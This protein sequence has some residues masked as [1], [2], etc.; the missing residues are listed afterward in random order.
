MRRS[1]QR[2][3]YDELLGVIRSVRRRWR[4]RMLLRGLAVVGAVAVA[5]LL[6]AGALLSA[7][8]PSQ[9]GVVAVR[10]AA[11][12]VIGL[13]ALLFLVRPLFRRVTD[14]DV[15]LYLEEHEPSLEAAVLSALEAGS[16]G[17]AG[18]AGAAGGEGSTRQRAAAAVGSDALLRRTLEQAIRRCHA[19][20]DG[21][22]VEQRS[23]ARAAGALALV[24]VVGALAGFLGPEGARLGAL[25]LFSAPQPV[26]AAGAPAIAVQ[27]GNATVARGA[28]VTI[29]ARVRNLDPS[30]VELVVQS[31]GDSVF[32]RLP[33]ARAADGSFGYLLFDLEQDAEYRVEAE[34]VRS[35]PFSLTVAELPYVD[36]L[37]LELRF[38][39][40]TGLPD[41][42]VEE[43][44][45]VTALRGTTARLTL[46]STVPVTAG[47]IVVD[48]GA[49]VPLTYDS[50]SGTLSGE[51]D[52]RSDGYYHIVL[53]AP[54][55]DVVEASPRYVIDALSDGEPIVAFEEPGRDERRTPIEEL[56][57]EARAEDDYGVADLTLHY[58]VNGGPERTEELYGGGGD[59]AEVTAG[60]TLY[61]EE[62]GLQP[63]DLI[64]YWATASDND[65]FAGGKAATS[66]IYF[67]QIRPFEREFRAAEQRQPPQGGQQGGQQDRPDGDLSQR[68]RQIV[69]G[70]FNLVRDS[71]SFDATDL[72]ES[73]NT[74]TL[75]QER[76]RD[77]AR[78]LA[79]RMQARRVTQDS[80][81]Q[82]IA[83]LLPQAAAEMDAAVEALR[84]GTVREALGPEQRALVLL[85]RAEAVFRE[86]QVSLGQQMGG[87]GQPG[88]APNA[89]D[90]ADL[91]ELEMDKLQ[92][93][94]E[95]V[96][97]GG[98]GGDSTTA[99]V[100]EAAERLE[101]L[102][103]RQQRE[104]E[105]RRREAMHGRGTA[106]GEA[107]RALAEQVEEE[108]RRLE[109]LSR[110]QRRPEL[111]EAARRLRDAAESMRRA[112]ASGQG[113]GSEQAEGAVD[114]LRDAR[115][116]LERTETDDLRRE[117]EEASQRADELAR[118]QAR[119]RREA[120]RL[121]ATAQGEERDERARELE[122]QK[123]RQQGDVES[124]EQDLRRLAGQAGAEEPDAAQQLRDAAGA[125]SNSQVEEKID[126]SRQLTRG[127]APEEY[128]RQLE[129]QIQQDLERVSQRLE[130]V[131]Q[132]IR[133]DRSEDG[134]ER[135]LEEA[136]DLARGL[137]SMRERGRELRE[138]ASGNPRGGRGGLNPDAIRQYRSEARQRLEDARELQQRLRQGGVA[139]GNL[140]EQMEGVLEGLDRLTDEG[141]YQDPEELAR[142]QSAL[143]DS[144]KR[145]ELQ[146]RIRL[147]GE[148]GVRLFQGGDGAV[149]AEYRELVEEYYRSLS[150]DGGQDGPGRQEDRQ[151]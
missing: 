110:D 96:N 142:L 47:G 53:E 9:Q 69:A 147:A 114:R 21:R 91:F 132:A 93:Q 1:E 59:L 94:Y 29:S 14:T 124:L 102:A 42:E 84:S 27:P 123:A 81:F 74:L 120:E 54:S 119:I 51:F 62:L 28:D 25:R 11:A 86:V 90:L 58:T 77:D 136:G 99:E 5:A 70:T 112:A 18:A 48:G 128:V 6:G 79:G 100:D 135:A 137:E 104:A 118:E 7:L 22:W 10:V 44:G 107:Q 125:I 39:A 117:A 75:S 3:A 45:D 109:R 33:M 72:R 130:G 2:M 140:E 127:G 37:G 88:G 115:R 52:V 20:D 65:G 106:G 98:G 43:G 89:E 26:E 151:P 148:Q 12:V 121:Q 68:Q 40:Y 17:P 138:S 34:G 144:A 50:A 146:L 78:T 16:E 63:G 8:E 133:E 38:P 83:R 149:P 32:E 57:L 141:L 67:V 46:T 66:D 92:D 76:L 150:R 108:A 129:E 103:R 111:Q 56:F 49:P 64:S 35:Q 97:R 55:G 23:L 131:E 87:G 116:L 60:H 101:E 73:V 143:A 95:T 126:F 113:Q 30:L 36:E 4:G 24:L 19:I 31:A 134:E 15:A 85:Q 139:Q 105:R 61:L 41:R 82:L 145:L 80:S 13:A 122:Q 71:A